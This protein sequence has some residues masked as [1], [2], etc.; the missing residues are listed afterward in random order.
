[1]RALSDYRPL[2]TGN[3]LERIQN[4]LDIEQEPQ[5]TS[6]GKPPAAWP[7]SGDL[8]IEKLSARYSIDGPEVLHSLTFSVKAGEKVGVVGRTGSGK[9]SLTLSLLRLIPTSGE[10]WYDGI[11]TSKTNL[12]DLRGAMTII[13]QQPELLVSIHVAARNSKYSSGA[14]T[15]SLFFLSLI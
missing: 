10:V 12:E 3:G 14:D 1:M 13:P 6:E 7:T 4:Y 5:A 9:S 8:V 11:R 15:D 2:L